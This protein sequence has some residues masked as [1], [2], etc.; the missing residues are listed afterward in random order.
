MYAFILKQYELLKTIYSK[1]TQ[2]LSVEK[3]SYLKGAG[4]KI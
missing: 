1:K 4:M 3:L 2:T